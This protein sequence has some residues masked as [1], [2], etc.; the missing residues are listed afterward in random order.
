MSINCAKYRFGSYL[1]ASLV[2]DLQL[3]TNLT[4]NATGD[5][6][7]IPVISSRKIRDQQR[8]AV[9]TSWL[10]PYNYSWSPH[11][12]LV[13]TPSANYTLQD[14]QKFFKDIGFEEG[15]LMRKDTEP[16]V[17][18][19]APPGV[20]LHCL[21]GTGVDTPDSFFYET[22]PDKEPKIFYGDGDGTVNLQSALQC[23]KWV[24]RQ[25]QDVT[26]FELPRSEHI[27]ML[28]NPMT[29]SYVKKVLLNLW[30][31]VIGLFLQLV[32]VF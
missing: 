15:W 24:G 7:R 11:K 30:H 8:S 18:E 4:L 20:R 12:I 28:Y 16:L 13:R 31:S 10:L 17:Y 2:Y 6:N 22:F 29:I 14:Y 1:I 26:L 25:K 21:Y 9:S 27:D 32:R 3:L 19:M 23:R 5:N